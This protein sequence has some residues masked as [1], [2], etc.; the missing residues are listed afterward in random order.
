[1]IKTTYQTPEIRDENDNIIQEGAFGKNTALSNATNDGWTDYVIN[2]LEALH[3]VVGESSPTLDANGHVV[4][5][6]NL[7]IGDEDGNRI[8]TSYLKT[9]GGTVNG[10]VNIAQNLKMQDNQEN[11]FGGMYVPASSATEQYLQLYGGENTGVAGA[12]LTLRHDGDGRFELTAKSADG[13]N[14][15]TLTNNNSGALLWR[16]SELA[17]KASPAFTGT[18]TAPTPAN[19][20]NSTKIAT[21]AFV[22]NNYLPLAGGTMTGAIRVQT[23][24]IFGINVR[25]D[26]YTVIYGGTGAGNGARIILRGKDYSDAGSFLIA[27]HNGVAARELIGKPDGTLTWAG[28]NVI[29]SAGG[30]MTGTITIGANVVAL[31]RIDNQGSLNLYGGNTYNGGA[32]AVFYG[33][34]YS[35]SSYA[36][37]FNIYAHDGANNKVLQGKTDGTLTWGGE[38]VATANNLS[39]TELLSGVP[40]LSVFSDYANFTVPTTTTQFSIYQG[41]YKKVGKI[42]YVHMKIKVTTARQKGSWGCAQGL[43][44]VN[45][46]TNGGGSYD[47]YPLDCWLFYGDSYA[48]IL[49]GASISGNG[50]VHIQCSDTL[51]V[52]P[53]D[54]D[55]RCII[56]HGFYYTE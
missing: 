19:G 40:D 10:A 30:T 37:T 20:D 45:G 28:N 44:K 1:M 17:P 27:A 39:G 12:K 31:K 14:T 54:R 48:G 25:D 2:N 5:P 32:Y 29:T 33:K 46:F 49:S 9:S 11:V 8:K 23:S 55:D 42:V 22:K 50:T 21:T 26:N 15:Y 38:N 53:T 41:G 56:I 7:A 3:D 47:F 4:E 6:A 43:P 52:T 35:N 24:G 51:P 34:D 16:G 18:P 36:G 13:G